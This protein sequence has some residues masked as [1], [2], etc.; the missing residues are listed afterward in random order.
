MTRSILF[1]LLFAGAAAGGAVGRHALASPADSGE[2]TYAPV[3]A[4]I[5]AL[6]A[7]DPAAA[8]TPPPPGNDLRV[9]VAPARLARSAGGESLELDVA[10]TNPAAVDARVKYAFEVVDDRG[11]VV[12]PAA[13]SPALRLTAG[14]QRRVSVATPAGLPDGYYA[15]RVTV[16][17]RSHRGAG[18][19]GQ[20]TYLRIEGGA[21]TPVD[22]STFH[23]ESRAH[24]AH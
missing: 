23:D 15:A 24:E 14:E 4:T 5:G 2:V 19:D 9:E 22:F 16:A 21:I 11:A 6:G 1:G 7:G 8:L 10:I 17:L 20:T 13:I 18:A 12:A 3:P